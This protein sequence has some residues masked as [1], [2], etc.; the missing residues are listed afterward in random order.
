MRLLPTAC[1]LVFALIALTPARGYDR[2]RWY[3]PDQ[4]ERTAEKITRSAPPADRRCESD[5]RALLADGRLRIAV[6]FGYMNL[7]YSGIVF[8]PYNRYDLQRHLQR[9]CPPRYQAC[10]FELDPKQD[11]RLTK[12]LELADGAFLPVE[13]HLRH[14]SLT[15]DYR[16]AV[17]HPP[18]GQA[19]H[20]AEVRQAFLDS[21]DGAD[22]VF[23]LGHSRLGSGPGFTPFAGLS[24]PWFDAW[25][26]DPLVPEITDKL[27][28]GAHPPKLIGLLACTTEHYYL[29]RLREAS[30]GSTWIGSL[31]DTYP[32]QDN[33]VLLGA[34]N[35]LLGRYCQDDFRQALRIGEDPGQRY[36]LFE[37]LDQPASDDTFEPLPWMMRD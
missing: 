34:L 8:D 31:T 15:D 10:G 11:G 19:E 12:T 14:S 24:R 13:I 30:P 37:W 20:S 2:P 25:L 16:T 28:Y 9:P 3:P 7:E 26:L 33:S 29:D 32:D 21:L 35:A 27:R 1:A 18:A 6:F 23:Y 17:E 36:K 5:Y 22:A 4:L